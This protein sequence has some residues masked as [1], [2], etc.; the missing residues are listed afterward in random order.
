MNPALYDRLKS[1]VKMYGQMP[2]Q[3]FKDP[4]PAR[5]RTTA[6]REFIWRV[7]SLLRRMQEQESPFSSLLNPHVSRML[8]VWRSKLSQG[9]QDFIGSPGGAEPMCV[10]TEESEFHHSCLYYLGSGEERLA[11]CCPKS[12]FIPAAGHTSQSVV[13][14]WGN[15]DGA[16]HVLAFTGGVTKLDM[17][18]MDLVR[19]EGGSVGRCTY[20]WVRRGVGGCPPLLVQVECVDGACNGQLII[21]AGTLGVVYCWKLENTTQV[22]VCVCVVMA[23]VMYVCVAMMMVSFHSL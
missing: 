13:A 4:H 2:L 19:E 9:G 21:A 15:W 7:G 23:T 5:H 16:V 17:P 18:A 10:Y 3:L 14:K 22:C 20:V 6:L 12:V 11:L 1:E 8:A